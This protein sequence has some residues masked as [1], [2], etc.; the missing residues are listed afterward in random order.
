ML[1]L[2]GRDRKQNKPHATEGPGRSSACAVRKGVCQQVWEGQGRGGC[3]PRGDGGLEGQ[4][5]GGEPSSFRLDHKTDGDRLTETDAS[6][7][8]ERETKYRQTRR[9]HSSVYP[10]EGVENVASYNLGLFY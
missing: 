4:T 3:A 9:K 5:D 10:S 6:G 1:C 8:T 7:Q 2:Q